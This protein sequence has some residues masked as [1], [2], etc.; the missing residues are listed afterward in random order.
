M[1]NIILIGLRGS[2]KTE[3][4]KILS[5]KLNFNFIDLDEE[6]KKLVNMEIPKIVEKFGWDFFRKKEH[7]I[8]KNLKD[9]TKT[10]IATGGGTVTFERNAKIIKRLGTII[11]LNRTPK[12][13]LK[14]IEHDKNNFRPSLTIA[15]NKLTEL[16]ELFI[17]RD[18]IYKKYCDL[19]IKR[20][21]DLENNCNKIIKLLTKHLNQER[22][23]TRL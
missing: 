19:E 22:D 3:L 6:I 5:K 7:A 18:P 21:D 20:T 16:E 1:N 14:Y 17:V 15:S 4:G 8:V 10:V 2:G 9:I 23:L 12:E 11:Y 13:C